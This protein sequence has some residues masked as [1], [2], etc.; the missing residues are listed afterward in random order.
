LNLAIFGNGQLQKNDQNI[1]PHTMLESTQL[2]IEVT[3]EVTCAQIDTVED[4]PLV[5]HGKAWSQIW[6][7]NKG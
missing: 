3:A 5:T 2:T 6:F 1:H 7:Y 4:R